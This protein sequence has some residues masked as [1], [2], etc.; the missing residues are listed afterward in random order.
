M[1]SF[2]HADCFDAMK[3]MIEVDV[4]CKIPRIITNDEDEEVYRDD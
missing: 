3:T 1:S 4:D 2:Y